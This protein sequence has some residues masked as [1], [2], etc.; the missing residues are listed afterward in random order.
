[1]LVLLLQIRYFE[2]KSASLLQ[3]LRAEESVLT[4]ISLIFQATENS[5]S[6]SNESEVDTEDETTESETNRI[7]EPETTD[8]S[9]NES[10]F[11]N[12]RDRAAATSRLRQ[13]ANNDG[14]TDNIKKSNSKQMPSKPVPQVRFSIVTSR[15]K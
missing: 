8:S 4:K 10:I 11:S 9:H 13:I 7:R 12:N 2:I 15:A 1:M 14:I 6:E 5:Y 3:F